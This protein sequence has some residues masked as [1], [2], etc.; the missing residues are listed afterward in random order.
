M[1]DLY[2]MQCMY[3]QAQLC[4]VIKLAVLIGFVLVVEHMVILDYTNFM[5]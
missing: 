4:I 2:S 1:H 5:V 3:T